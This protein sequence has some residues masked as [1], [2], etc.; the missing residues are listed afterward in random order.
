MCHNEAMF[1]LME[2]F[3]D[4]IK[5]RKLGSSL[6]LLI[7]ITGL[8][9]QVCPTQTVLSQPADDYSQPPLPEQV[10]STQRGLEK[11]AP[12]LRAVVENT[13]VPLSVAAQ[14][15]VRQPQMVSAVV[16]PGTDVSRFFIR[17][18]RS[19]QFAG[20]QW[21]NGEIETAQL[22]KLA[23]LPDVLG[24]FSTNTYHTAEAPGL[25]DLRAG[26]PYLE[27]EEAQ[28]LL[29]QGGPALL[30]QR[31]MR[32]P[33]LKPRQVRA[34]Q[35]KNGTRSATS[36]TPG[37][38]DVHDVRRAWDAGYKGDGVVVALVDTGVDFSH[39]D[40]Q[41]TQAVI[42]QGPY[43][44]WPFAYDVIS[45]AKYAMAPGE[46]LDPNN[47]WSM[48]GKT[49]YARTLPVITKTCSQL[50]CSAGLQLGADP[51]TGVLV[52]VSF[53][54]TSQSGKYLYT[55]H[56]DI[57][58]FYVA[59]YMHA[60]YL[61]SLTPP[62]M[63]VSDE[64]ESGIYDTV[65]VDVNYNGLL[66]DPGEKLTR[67]QPLGGADLT[68][69]GFWD[70]SA[71]MLAW[72]SDGINHPPGVAALYPDILEKDPPAQGQLLAFITDL[73][74][75]GTNCASEIAGQ[76]QIS[77]PEGLGPINPLY[78]GG[79]EVGGVGTPVIQGMAP[80]TKIAA[81]QNGFQLPLDAWTLAVIG[82]DGDQDQDDGAQIVSNSWG[83]SRTIEDGWDPVSRFAQ[84]LSY[85]VAPDVSFLVAT[86]NGGHG[87]GTVTSPAGASII[88]VGAS[89]A[90]GSLSIF[91][92]TTPEQFLFGDVQPWSNRGPGALGDVAPDIVAVG[93]WG[94]GAQPLN[95]YYGN[96]QAAYDVFGGTSMSTPVAA[97]ALSLIYQAFRSQPENQR[98]P[99]WEEARSILL[100][101]AQDL[102]YDVFT[103]GSG[104]VRAGRSVDI[105]SDRLPWVSPQQWQVGDYRGEKYPAFPN[106]IYSGNPVSQQFTVNNPTTE[107]ITY[108]VSESYLVKQY[109]ETF[110]VSFSSP[111]PSSQYKLPVFL[112]NLT[113][114]IDQYD[115]ALVRAQVSLPYASFDINNDGY[116]DN[117]WGV[118]FYDWMDHNQDQNLWVDSDRDGVVDENEIDIDPVSGIYEFNRFTYGYPQSTRIEASLGEQAIS[119]AHDG[120][121][122]GLDCYYCGEF[123]HAANSLDVL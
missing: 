83:D 95:Y 28:D 23:S 10:V 109:E 77:D 74:G 8:L 119:R 4:S 106:L 104:N 20:Y 61:D 86:G 108:Q 70:L 50:F 100:N 66:G 115:P 25:E 19:R 13:Q 103:Q 122:L 58:L 1:F 92:N 21:V 33:S 49:Q 78:A 63:I 79:A 118:Y 45:G 112:E 102:G 101:G 113:S 35:T 26:F 16:R 94:T 84:Q 71:G 97:G 56:P 73:D 48:I 91:E 88:D 41:G 36:S 43:A 68:G 54:N 114:L 11:L 42:S 44:G 117:W 64:N 9:V 65:Y 22:L 93:A 38:L 80:E 60:G 90:Y 87:Y 47:I 17:S 81:F 52:N 24:I 85:E 75:H 14:N 32:E 27:I 40:L 111:A 31:L 30:L 99:T 18:A 53:P 57:L 5:I 51:E 107:E 123:G 89:T 55:I 3:K 2:R 69:D 59:Y 72:I 6:L 82:M 7:L 110:T 116:T 46:I 96:G 105:V 98:W 121:F 34:E 29:A 39:P 67:D 12:D 76:G 62:L 15:N 37:L 120:I